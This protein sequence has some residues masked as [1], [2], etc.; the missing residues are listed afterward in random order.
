MPVAQ[1]AQTIPF[2]VVVIV[3]AQAEPVSVISAANVSN[4]LLIFYPPLE[5]HGP[6][7]HDVVVAAV[8]GFEPDGLVEKTD[9]RRDDEVVLLRRVMIEAEQEPGVELLVICGVGREAGV[10]ALPDGFLDVARI[11]E[12]RLVGKEDAPRFVI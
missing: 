1:N 6:V 2:T 11:H 9:D 4:T 3:S 8:S 12:A 10:S 7:D 5:L